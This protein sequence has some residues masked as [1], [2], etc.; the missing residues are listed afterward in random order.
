MKNLILAGVRMN[1]LVKGSEAK[2][3]RAAVPLCRRAI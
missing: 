1:T 3:A 2:L